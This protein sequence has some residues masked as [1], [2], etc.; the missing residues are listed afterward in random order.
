M[1]TDQRTPFYERLAD[2]LAIAIYA[3]VFVAG[4]R[5]PSIRRLAQQ[6]HL[7]VSTVVQALQLLETRGLVE[8]RPQAGFYVRH[9]ARVVTDHTEARALSSSTHVGVSNFLSDVIAAHNAPGLVH[10][11]SALPTE[12]LLP[13]ARLQRD[14]GAVARRAGKLFSH[15][16]YFDINEPQFL[17]QIVRRSLDWGQVDAGEIVVTSSC[18]EAISLCLRA[19]TKPG[20]TVA[21]E[22]AS[23]FVL[24]QLLE[25]LGLKALEIPM[26]PSTGASVDALELAMREGLVNACLLT[27]NVNN[28]T[29]SIM[30][31]ADKKRL[32]GLASRFD[33]PIIEDDVYRELVFAL[34]QPWPL[35]AYDETGNVLLC[36]S[37]SKTLG[38]ALRVG[39]VAAGKYAAR[40]AFLKTVSSGATSH[41]SQAVVADFIGSSRFD[42]H[43]RKIRR[44]M[45]QR[46]ATMRQAVVEAFPGECLVSEPQG[47]FV[48]WVTLPPDVDVLALHR[49]AL[50]QRIA[51]MPGPL[52]SA[53]GQLGHHLRLNCVHANEPGAVAAMAM[54][55]TCYPI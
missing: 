37:F 43:L 16:G 30:P 14:V 3:Q 34:T 54:L 8:A 2:E 28:P 50:A 38:P 6:K 21:V 36:S 41:L 1:S 11:G 24:L 49:E 26:H 48:L 46:I 20:D 45:A 29:G 47:G 7:S 23:F 12:E 55:V 27:P 40:V 17:R 18:T 25:S 13:T 33:I 32:A 51:F 5:L 53:S 42:N 44:L 4:E 35:K 31:E 10:L 15:H 9:R 19:V 52:F 39:Y 22:S